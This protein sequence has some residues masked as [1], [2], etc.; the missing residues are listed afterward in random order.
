MRLGPGRSSRWLAVA[1]LIPLLAGWAGCG[2]DRERAGVLHGRVTVGG[3]PL[4]GGSVYAVGGV[5]AGE[6]ATNAAVAPDG[7]YEMSGVPVGVVRIALLP[8]PGDAEDAVPL[9]PK[10]LDTKTSGLT[11]EVRPGRQVYDVAIP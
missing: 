5:A 8:P 2:R 3:R 4:A 1:C 10:F 7:S 9:P 6:C 11:V